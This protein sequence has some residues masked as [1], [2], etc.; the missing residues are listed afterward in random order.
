MRNRR[1][2][3]AATGLIIGLA[4]GVG[5][6]AAL[7]QDGQTDEPKI[8]V[9]NLDLPAEVPDFTNEAEGW[10]VDKSGEFATVDILAEDHGEFSIHVRVKT[11]VRVYIN[12]SKYPGVK[13]Y[14]FTFQNTARS[15]SSPC[16]LGLR[17]PRS[18]VLPF[19]S[20]ANGFMPSMTTTGRLI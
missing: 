20:Q 10:R 11:Q 6:L 8:K 19:R 15:E 7:A 13:I 4:L 2:R 3:V 5:N 14:F 1:N 17:I 12:E 9:T 18:H 16:F